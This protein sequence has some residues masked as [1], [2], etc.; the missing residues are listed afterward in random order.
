MEFYDEKDMKYW[1]KQSEL[2]K[3]V[4]IKIPVSMLLD[5]ALLRA[6]GHIDLT[7]E[8]GFEG[9]LARFLQLA[10]LLVAHVEELFDAEHV[11]MIGN[12]HTFHTVTDSFVYQLLDAGLTVEYRII[13]MYVQVYEVFHPISFSAKI[14]QIM[15]TAK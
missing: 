6:V 1:Q 10:V 4:I 5:L 7:T 12:G 3:A 8:D 14:L 2:G 15:Q 9:F 13:C 11:S